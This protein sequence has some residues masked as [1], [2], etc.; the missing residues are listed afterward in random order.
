M[1][2]LF[3][4]F[5]LLADQALQDK[6]FDPSRIDDLMRLFEVDAYNAWSAAEAEHRRAAGV[7]EA[8]MREAEAQ[9]SSLMDAAMEEFGKTE[10]ILERM[11]VEEL[12][13]TEAALERTATG[14]ASRLVAAAKAAKR[15]GHALGAAASAASKKYV[16]AA[17]ASAMA[18]MR[19]PGNGFPSLP[20]VHPS[21]F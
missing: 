18:T 21:S 6:S 9:L 19:S 1:E 4:Q 13:K 11:A 8:S 7:A 10:A 3:S 20:K 16:D 12:E 2:S 5:S 17:V 14:E 15:M